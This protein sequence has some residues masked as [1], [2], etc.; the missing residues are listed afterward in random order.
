MTESD[1]EQLINYGYFG[2]KKWDLDNNS[3]EIFLKAKAYCDDF[4]VIGEFTSK[5]G[6]KTEVTFSPMIV[7]ASTKLVVSKISRTFKGLF[8]DTPELEQLVKQIRT[9]FQ[10][11]DEEGDQLISIIERRYGEDEFIIRVFSPNFFG[12]RK[13]FGSNDPLYR[14]RPP[15]LP[16]LKF[17]S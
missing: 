16:S 14:K 11:F 12:G 9:K 1:F 13:T 6:L 17:P 8:R 3:L 15:G 7:G 10:L 5:G 2:D 4:I